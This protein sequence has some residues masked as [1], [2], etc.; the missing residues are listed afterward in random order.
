MSCLFCFSGDKL[1]PEERKG[2]Y[3]DVWGQYADNDEAF[4]V[5][6]CGAPCAEPCCWIGSMVCWPCGQY[7]LRYMV[8]NHQEPGS[9][10]KNY[11]CCQGLFGGCCC[12]QPGNLG[13][14]SCPQL[15]MCLEGCC[16]AGMAVSASQGVIMNQYNLGLDSDD[17]RLIRCNNCLQ[18][19]AI[20][21]SCLNI[22]IDFDGDDA[23]VSLLNL[24][25]DVTFCCVSGCMTARTYHEVKIREKEAPENFRMQR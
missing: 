1:S 22:C 21:A 13:E 19:L 8:L 16:C 18:F 3:G 6:L 5:K 12:I 15:C 23:I 20:F 4:K 17:V 14:E 9:G 2:K 25:A 24:I 7:K 10:W 11:T